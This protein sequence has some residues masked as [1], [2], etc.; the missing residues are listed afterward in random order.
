MKSLCWAQVLSFWPSKVWSWTFHT[1]FGHFHGSNCQFAHFN[2]SRF[3]SFARKK[4][5]ICKFVPQKL[6][7]VSSQ[8]MTFYSYGVLQWKSSI[9]A[10]CRSRKRRAWWLC[11]NFAHFMR[12]HERKGKKFAIFSRKIPQRT[13]NYWKLEF[14]ATICCWNGFWRWLQNVLYTR[15]CKKQSKM[16][17]PINFWRLAPMIYKLVFAALWM[18]LFFIAIAT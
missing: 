4:V 9:V 17:P 7:A 13:S 6:P 16:V 5:L 12:K 18:Q 11:N 3:H 8:N 15:S 1:G 14:K 2:W 10:K